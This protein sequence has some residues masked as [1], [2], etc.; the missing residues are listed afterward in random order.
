MPGDRGCFSRDALHQA[1]V[2]AHDVDVVVEDRE[3]RSVVAVGEPFLRDGHPH[4][5]RGA[6][7]ERPRRAFHSRHPVILG[8]TGRL[9]ADLPE[10]ANVFQRHR[11]LSQ[12]LVV[13]VHRSRSG[14][15]ENRP[16][17]HRGV[18]VGQHEPIAVRPDRVRRIETHHA[19]PDRIDERRQRHRCAGVPGL[20]ALDRIDRERANRVDRQLIELG[21]CH[22]LVPVGWSYRRAT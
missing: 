16:E 3:P 15:M 13:G 4:A 5:R 20:G 9:A 14:Q 12:P 2:S 8:V 19:V 11:R 21:V 7:T 17:E 6:L 18:T 1:P 10:A 22:C